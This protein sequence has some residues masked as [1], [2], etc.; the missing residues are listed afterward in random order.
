MEKTYEIPEL[1][2]IGQAEEV[3]MGS[4][5]FGIDSGNDTAPDFD[6]EQD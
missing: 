2:F 5:P 6:F 4:I 3:V 1:T